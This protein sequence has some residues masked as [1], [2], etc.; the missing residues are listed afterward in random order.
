MR[1]AALAVP[2]TRDDS[3]SLNTLG[4]ALYRACDF[5][6]SIE[7]LEKSLAAGKGQSDGFD[8]VFLAM[9]HHRLGH[10]D[11][12]RHSLE[13]AIVW[14]AEHKSLRPEHIQEL[15]AF[16]AEAERVLAGPAGEMPDDV[17]DS[18]QS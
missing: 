4:V 14:V 13:R 18:P 9:A 5:T 6:R 8:L 17:F 1:L 11:E 10:R 12:A 2:L 7:T 16:R 15:A 3:T